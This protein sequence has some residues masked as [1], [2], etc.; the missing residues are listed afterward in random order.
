MTFMRRPEKPPIAARLLALSA[1]GLTFLL[2][3]QE[4][5]AQTCGTGLGGDIAVSPSVAHV[6][7]T[8]TVN[9]V[10]VFS[11]LNA[12]TV[13]NG[14]AWI[15]Y[16][17]NSVQT[18]LNNFNLPPNSSIVCPG[19]AS[20]LSF[21]TTYVV[22]AADIG[23]NLSFQTNFPA[24][25]NFNCSSSGDSNVIHFEVA[26]AGDAATDPPSLA[27]ACQTRGVRIIFPGIACNKTCV[28]GVGQ[29]GAISFSG[30]V[31]NTGDVNLV[32]VSVSNLVNGVLT[33]VTNISTLNTNSSARFAGSYVPA[34]PCA[35]VMDTIFV[36]G[37]DLFGGVV[38]NTCSATCSNVI[39]PCISV[40]KT[41]P[42]PVTV[43]AN[44]TISGVVSNCGNVS[45]TNIA[46]TDNVLGGITNIARLEP[47]QAV[48]YSKSFV[49][50]CVG[51]T[52]TVTVRGT[53][54]C[55]QGVTNT[56]SAPCLVTENPCIRVTKTCSSSLVP[57]GGTVTFSGIV[58]NCGDI[59]LTNVVLN[60]TFLGRVI[61]VFPRLEKGGTTGS[62]Q[63]YS[64]NYVATAAD[65][66]RGT[67]TNTVIATGRDAC[68][69]Q[70]VQDTASCTFS[71][72][73]P[74]HQC[75]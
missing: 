75:K 58:T 2:A 42:G 68:N 46:V 7:D 39:T 9:F 64:T 47:Q 28:N 36:R 32:N 61:A 34:N 16:P 31:T 62:S 26:A 30:T 74:L 27:S 69:I 65:C 4:N 71:V 49:A 50:G 15:I 73:C 11:S 55:G 33:L 20:C 56:A 60:D 70:T 48:S 19:N 22:Q 63:P 43:G 57:V 72:I 53:T 6:G 10:E 40:T 17:N 41:C 21:T 24:G 52:N 29:N 1:L 45:I 35:P 3:T 44:Q 13:T 59:A 51:N 14:R 25:F 66:S 12:C 38:S 67:L 23:R 37:S 8:I 18:W 54:T 5:F